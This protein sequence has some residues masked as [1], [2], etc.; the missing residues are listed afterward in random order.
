MKKILPTKEKPTLPAGLTPY[1]GST[2]GLKSLL[3]EV[4]E[5]DNLASGGARLR[6]RHA[7]TRK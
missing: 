2:R 6:F 4:G 1:K 5:P 7:T 3:K